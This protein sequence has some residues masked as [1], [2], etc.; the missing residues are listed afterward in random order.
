MYCCLQPIRTKPPWVD[1]VPL[2]CLPKC[3]P[4]RSGVGSRASPYTAPAEE[5]TNGICQNDAITRLTG[6]NRRC[7]SRH[8][9]WFPIQRTNRNRTR[10]QS[11]NRRINTIKKSP[12]ILFDQGNDSF[13]RLP[14]IVCCVPG[15][16][17]Q[18][19]SFLDQTTPFYVNRARLALY[20]VAPVAQGRT[21]R[22]CDE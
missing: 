3:Y 8:V 12:E 19:A 16:N 10:K 20:V 2:K 15:V 9:W 22:A 17:Q 18:F 5:S 7:G 14:P 6:N 11:P 4:Y 1:S 21:P 13:V